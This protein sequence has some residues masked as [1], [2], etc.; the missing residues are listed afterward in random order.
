MRPALRGWAVIAVIVAIGWLGMAGGAEAA[1]VRHAVVIGNNTGAAGEQ[2]LQYAEADARKVF[3]VLHDLGR[4]R[5]ENMVLL[6]DEDVD[7]VRRT[8]I[9]VNE[10]VRG[11]RNDGDDVVLFVYYSGHADAQALHLGKGRFETSELRQLVRGSSADVRVL[12]LDACRSGSLTRVKGAKPAPRFKI[13][14]DERLTEEG[15]VFLTSSTANEDAQESD[16]LK[17][18][19]F[20]HYFVSGLVGPADAN[21]DGTVSIEEAYAHA[22]D[23]TLR[24]SSQT[25]HGVQHPTFM[26]RLRGRG[27]L[28]LT[29]VGATAGDRAKLRFPKGRSYLVF[30]GSKDGAVVAEVGRRD[31]VRDVSVEAGRYFVRGRAADHLLEGKVKV[32]AGAIH[33]VSDRELKRIEFARLARKGGAAR[34]L[35][36]GPQGGYQ[37]HS[38]LWGDAA[39][40]HGARLGYAV[41]HRWLSV[42]PRVGF[43]RSGFTNAAVRAVADEYDLDVTLAHVFDVPVLSIGI[44]DRRRGHIAA[45][46]LRH[47]ARRPR[48]HDGGR[49]HRR[50]AGTDVGPAAGCVFSDRRLGAGPPLPRRTGG[51]HTAA[52]GPHRA[53]LLRPRQAVLSVQQRHRPPGRE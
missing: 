28:P 29:W 9:A 34:R 41:E 14:L 44:W 7:T 33:V 43:C 15:M 40:C 49:S 27:D 3:G 1:I 42:I 21:R 13:E 5:P 6:L 31:R 8:L 35:A 51:E 32:A 19:F 10:R 37:L 4:F 30:A 25:L 26:M 52:G 23:S 18:S 11:H 17:G 36:H 50:G 39:I 16:E 38:P 12:M 45:A 20:T 48:Q 24:A 2:R 46:D 53:R 47:D 22:Y